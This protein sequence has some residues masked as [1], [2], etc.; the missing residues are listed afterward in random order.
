MLVQLVSEDPDDASKNYQCAWSFDALGEEA[1][2]VPYYKKA[3]Q[4]GLGPQELEGALLWLGST[5]RTLGAYSKAQRT[6]LK[7]IEVFPHNKAFPAR[8]MDC[9]L[10]P[11]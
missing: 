9:L 8:D 10:S 5:Y 3:I 2:A 11:V 1:Q 7:G 6:L 4:L